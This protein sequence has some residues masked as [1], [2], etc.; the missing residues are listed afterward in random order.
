MYSTANTS[1]WLWCDFVDNPCSSVHQAGMYAAGTAQP[2]WPPYHITR[3]VAM[4]LSDDLFAAS[5]RPSEKKGTALGKST[6]SSAST[7]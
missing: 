3:R 1:Y 4:A 2:T 5:R 7:V 6:H